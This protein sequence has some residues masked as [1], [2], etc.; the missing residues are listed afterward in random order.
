MTERN[1]K[2]CSEN[3]K[4]NFKSVLVINYFTSNKRQTFFN[5]AKNSLKID[6][7]QNQI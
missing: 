7:N 4:L 5:L 3:I 1:K 2:V 6:K